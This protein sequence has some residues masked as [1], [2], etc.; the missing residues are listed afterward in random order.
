MYALIDCNNFYAS[1]ERAF[2][3][4]LIDKPVVV[5]SNNDGCVIA[6][7]NEAKALGI[8]MGAPAYQY[9]YTFEQHDIT[10]FSANFAL[11]GDMSHRVMNIL[12]GY[13]H[14]QEI[15]SIDECFLNLSGIRE[16][17]HDYGVKMRIHVFKWTG[18]PVSV[19]VAPTKA[20]AKLA[21]RIA[22]KFPERTE[23]SYVIDTDDKRIKALRWM[24]VEDVWGIGRRNAKKLRSIGVNTAYD[25]T[26]LD[27]GWI[28]RNMTIVGVRLL[29]ELNGISRLDMEPV[30]KKQSIAT[31]R[32]FE[33][34]YRSYEELSERITTFTVTSAEKLRKQQSRCNSIAVFIETSRFREPD[35]Q[36]NNS[37]VVKLPFPSSS[38]MEMVKFVIEGLKKIYKPEYLYKRAGVV[39]M[40]FVQEE[41]VIRSFFFNSDPKH[42]PLMKVID[43]LNSK[44]GSQKI[45]LATQDTKVW[46]M[47]QE[48]L[49]KRFTTDINDIL[50]VSI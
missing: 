6:R 26:Q 50:D 4:S 10:V 2:N 17:L 39:L 18:I 31:T 32:T 44:F 49:S 36:Y 46:K 19:G 23:G 24:P 45:R 1:C 25:F 9:Q 3:P 30:E 11:Y 43:N 38:T 41:H 42:E 33:R 35:D 37:I 22:K 13:S 34:E 21:N 12:S 40:D 48:R 20:L 47:K 15:Y 27:R 7:S 5:L 29:D 28:L 8:P 14:E 16:D